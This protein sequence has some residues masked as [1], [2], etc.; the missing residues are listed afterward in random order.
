M[1]VWKTNLVNL[2]ALKLMFLTLLLTGCS[3][4]F[5][6]SYGTKGQT[7]EAFTR[8]VE[9]VFKLQNSLTSE[10][11]EF[12]ETD[13]G[14]HDDLLDAE[15]HMQE[16]CGPL[17]E[18]ATRESEGLSPGF[19]LSRRVEKTALDCEQAAEKVKTLLGH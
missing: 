7:K 19:M 17:N 1:T 16:A 8:Y 2:P 10:I 18:Y 4:S 5:F 6:G 3:T 12:M 13:V 11:M 15:Q 9:S 14:N